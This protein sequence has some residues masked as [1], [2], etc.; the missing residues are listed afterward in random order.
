MPLGYL[1]CS[2]CRGV[3]TLEKEK[4][5]CVCCCIGC[6]GEPPGFHFSIFLLKRTL[7][8]VMLG[9]Q[10]ILKYVVLKCCLYV[11]D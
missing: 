9:C 7:S 8:V 10:D 6:V 4:V 11:T 5:M 2:R 3:H 1:G